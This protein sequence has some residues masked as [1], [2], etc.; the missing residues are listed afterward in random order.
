[1]CWQ[2]NSY[3]LFSPQIFQELSVLWF[4]HM[5]SVVKK[6]DINQVKP[7][8]QWRKQLFYLRNLVPVH[9]TYTTKEI[10]CEKSTEILMWM[11]PFWV[12]SAVMLT[13]YIN[14]L[15]IPGQCELMRRDMWLKRALSL[16]PLFKGPP[17]IIVIEGDTG[18]SPACKQGFCWPQQPLLYQ[19]TTKT[20][21]H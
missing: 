4:R 19:Q 2:N 3:N 15:T 5:Q 1:M 12:K 8:L 11:C 13:T 14:I 16:M 6:R 7:S 10:W 18:G 9:I 21:F 17:P 20:H